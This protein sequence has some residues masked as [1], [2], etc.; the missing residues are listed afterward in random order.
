MSR[1]FA[2]WADPRGP[3]RLRPETVHNPLKGVGRDL[4][5]LARSWRWAGGARYPGDVERL[6]AQQ[7]RSVLPVPVRA[8]MRD[9]LVG[10]LKRVKVEVTGLTSRS[11]EPRV[12][13][14]H[15]ESGA[16]LAVLLESIP[17]SWKVVT[18]RLPRALAHGRSVLVVTDFASAAAADVVAKASQLATR[19]GRPVVPVVVRRLAVS[20]EAPTKL[21]TP[22]TVDEVL[23]RYGE[24]I[25]DDNPVAVAQRAFDEVGDLLAEDDATWWKVVSGQVSSPL[26][27]SMPS[28]RRLWERTDPNRDLARTKRRIWR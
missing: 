3:Y 18:A 8:S 5:L 9:P 7:R 6:P 15:V 20:R 12:A 10:W 27:R 14:A 22:R 24:E 28:W 11:A 4:A 19:Y 26:V 23:V 13:L 2:S 21:P 17:A 25:L 16:D 1:E